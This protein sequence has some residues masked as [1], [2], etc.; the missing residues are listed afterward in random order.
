MHETPAQLKR[1]PKKAPSLHWAKLNEASSIWGMKLLFLLYK[2]VGRRFVLLFLYPTVAWYLISQRTARAASADYLSRLYH[3]TQH[4]T[5]KP[6][7]IN[8]FR[9]LFA[10]AECILDKWVVW[11]GRIQELQHETQGKEILMQLA[12]AQRGAI[13]IVP[14]IGNMDL[15]RVLAQ[16]IAG[17]QLTV[18]MHTK[19]AQRFMNLLAKTNQTSAMNILQVSDFSLAMATELSSRVAQG[20]FI[21]IAGDRTPLSNESTLTVDFLGHPAPFPI[22]PYALAQA[23]QC[24]LILMIAAKEKNI[25]RLKL[26]LLADSQEH[27]TTRADRKNYFHQSIKNFA[28][29]L[30]QQCIKTPFQWF[31]FFPFWENTK[32]KAEYT[33]PAQVN[34]NVNRGEDN[35]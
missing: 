3:F 34:K 32:A 15:C 27:K 28:N 31:N 13:I 29:N 5:P 20:E 26:S 1:R 21:A 18:L 12:A 30:E 4:T 7:F 33:N 10:F 19:H 8:L 35:D 6:H 24:P 17:I 11:S 23:C 9:H 14:H 22:G 2:I 16:E 25:Y